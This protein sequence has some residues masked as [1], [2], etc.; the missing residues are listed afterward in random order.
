MKR[1]IT[2]LCIIIGVAAI[3]GIGLA[4]HSKSTS[5]STDTPS[6]NQVKTADKSSDNTASKTSDSADEIEIPDFDLQKEKEWISYYEDSQLGTTKYFDA[7]AGIIREKT[8]ANGEISKFASQ[9]FAN[10]YIIA[11][12]PMSP[13]KDVVILDGEISK[14]FSFLIDLSQKK[15]ISKDSFN[16]ILPLAKRVIEV[17]ETKSG[18]TKDMLLHGLATVTSTLAFGNPDCY[19]NPGDQFH[20][21]ATLESADNKHILKYYRQTGAQALPVFTLCTVTISD[22]EIQ[23]ESKSLD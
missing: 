2:A 1:M 23:F 7:A 9:H 10:Y 3:A 13:N 12:R 17:A 15:I 16:E 21:K 19:D 14:E 8:G 18:S 11:F 20:P 5:S 22:T 6:D 4:C